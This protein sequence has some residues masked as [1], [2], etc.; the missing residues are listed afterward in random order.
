MTHH[1][2]ASRITHHASRI[3][4][5][6]SRITQSCGSAGGQGGVQLGD[7]VVQVPGDPFL[8][9]DLGGIANGANQVLGVA[10]NVIGQGLGGTV[11]EITCNIHPEKFAGGFDLM[12]GFDPVPSVIMVTGR[13]NPV[14]VAQAAGF[15]AIAEGH[16]FKSI[17]AG[18]GCQAHAGGVGPG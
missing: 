13:K 8:I 9:F 4:H 10:E 17:S 12:H 15:G 3:T 7:G 5:H 14:S 6:A 2:H 18:A 1:Y 16:G 11:L